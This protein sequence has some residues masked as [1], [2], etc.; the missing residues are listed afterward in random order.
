MNRTFHFLLLIPLFFLY[1]C[2]SYR[3]PEKE[4]AFVPPTKSYSRA[5]LHQWPYEKRPLVMIDPGHGG[6]DNGTESKT[7]PQYQ[8]KVL[9]L[10][11]AKLVRHYLQQLGYR[12]LMTREA[13][14]F[15]PLSERADMA[16]KQ[17]AHLF[18]SVH[19][20][21]ASATT[22]EGVEVFYFKSEDQ[23]NRSP[24]SEEMG[25][26][27]LDSITTQTGARARGVKHAKFRVIRNTLMPAIL[28]ECGFLTHPEERLKIL[29]EPFYKQRL[30]TGIAEG[31]D[32]FAQKRLVRKK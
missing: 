21:S 24:A 31:V 22:A 28:V 14:V 4:I 3:P 7:P 11:T 29:Q 30:A 27:V 23:P 6:K 2:S 20:N 16:N 32:R 1:G 8:E 18:V 15:I 17:K 26:E 12:T 25:K 10:Q 13:D 9:A 5:P 19:Y